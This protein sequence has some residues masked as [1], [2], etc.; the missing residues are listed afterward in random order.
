MKERRKRIMKRLLVEELE[1][2][3]MLTGPPEIAMAATGLTSNSL[4]DFYKA[5]VGTEIGGPAG[6][7][8]VDEDIDMV[9]TGLFFSTVDAVLDSA[10]PISPDIDSGVGQ[11]TITTGANTLGIGSFASPTAGP[12][13]A[14]GTGN[15]NAPL[16][17]DL[18]A[19]D[20]AIEELFG[21]GDEESVAKTESDAAPVDVPEQTTS[22]PTMIGSKAMARRAW[23]IAPD[24][25]DV[26]QSSP[27]GAAA[28]L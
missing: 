2:R 12:S 15:L 7:Y 4:E 21:E 5:V 19:A 17:R 3:E 11:Q 8:M 6:V 9:P 13:K 23:N 14:G 27:A 25:L 28:D 24:E 22:A 10:E 26:E 18:A 20:A 16:L 1:R